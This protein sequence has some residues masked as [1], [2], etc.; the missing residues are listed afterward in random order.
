MDAGSNLSSVDD[1]ILLNENVV[2]DEKREEGNPEQSEEMEARD[3]RRER[4]ARR[5]HSL[6]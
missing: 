3:H 4:T 5:D 1:G 2:S 6:Q